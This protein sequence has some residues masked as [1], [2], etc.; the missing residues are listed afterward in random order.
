MEIQNLNLE[1][2][3]KSGWKQW[4]NYGKSR[5][6]FDVKNSSL[7][8]LDFYKSGRICFSEFKDEEISHSMAYKV[9]G[10]KVFIDLDTMELH[11]S[12]CEDEAEIV[13][14]IVK[15][16]VKKVVDEPKKDTEGGK[17]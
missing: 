2:A 6:Y 17:K 16:A 12:P 3:L 11:V 7:L 4:K 15:D 8:N 5:L 10:T 9:I 1:K 14:E 13:S